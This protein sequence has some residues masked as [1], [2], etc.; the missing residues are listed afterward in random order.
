[1]SVEAACAL[2]LFLFF[3]ISL[4]APMKMMDIHRQMQAALEAAGCTSDMS[5]T[6]ICEAMVGAM[7]TISYD[8][9][10]GQSMT[11]SADGTV[12]KAPMAVVIENG[13]YVLPQ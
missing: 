4:L 6:D 2:S 11:W 5:S 7:T 8:G 1:M 3:M 12:S 9:L 13:V 10:T